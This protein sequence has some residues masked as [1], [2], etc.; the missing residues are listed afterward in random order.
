MT[1]LSISRCL[2]KLAPLQKK[3]YLCTYPDHGYEFGVGREGRYDGHA[4]RRYVDVVFSPQG[5]IVTTLDGRLLRGRLF[6]LPQRT[7]FEGI[8][9]GDFFFTK[10]VP[11]AGPFTP[12]DKT[13]EPLTQGAIQVWHEATRLSFPWFPTSDFGS[14][15]SF[16]LT[17]RELSIN[18]G[19]ERSPSL[20]IGI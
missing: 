6:V 11:D 16:A 19:S 17:P 5:L 14:R 10:F 20:A 18:F 2:S 3:D 12:P 9:T 4:H 8:E 1:S 15:I 13:D 7:S